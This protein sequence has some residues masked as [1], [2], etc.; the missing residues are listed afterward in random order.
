MCPKCSLR[1]AA[2]MVEM[3]TPTARHR[4]AVTRA[5]T[6]FETMFDATLKELVRRYPLDWLAGLGLNADL[7][8]RA[9]D[10][11]LSTV[12]AEGDTVLGIG[13]PLVGGAD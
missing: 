6:K 3:V 13:D 7:P 2:R 5:T 4:A 9:L 12:S 10:V 11:D 1:R 8:V